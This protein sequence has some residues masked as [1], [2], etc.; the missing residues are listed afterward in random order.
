MLTLARDHPKFALELELLCLLPCEPE[1]AYL[2]GCGPGALRDDVI[3]DFDMG[4]QISIRTLLDELYERHALAIQGFNMIVDDHCG[5]AKR[6]ALRIRRNDWVRSQELCEEYL[7]A[8]YG[9]RRAF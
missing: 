3:R 1:H 4:H 6:R 9:K 8:V 5:K 7:L 2:D